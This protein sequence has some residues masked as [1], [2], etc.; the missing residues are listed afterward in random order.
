M[1]LIATCSPRK[2]CTDLHQWTGFKNTAFY[3]LKV[4]RVSPLLYVDGFKVLPW[5][6]RY[7]FIRIN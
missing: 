2:T 1:D 3:Q 7:S 4:G 5:V 6:V